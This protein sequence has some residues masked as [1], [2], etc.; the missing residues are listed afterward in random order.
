MPAYVGEKCVASIVLTKLYEFPTT[1]PTKKDKLS[2]T[3]QSDALRISAKPNSVKSL[4][5]LLFILV[6]WCYSESQDT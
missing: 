3:S 4:L 1:V 2:T 5:V 6:V